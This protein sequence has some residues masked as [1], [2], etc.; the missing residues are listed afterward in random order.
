MR[1]YSASKVKPSLN[2][3]SASAPPSQISPSRTH[4]FQ[5]PGFSSLGSM[6]LYADQD[7]HRLLSCA[8]QPRS[9]FSTFSYSAAIVCPLHTHTHKK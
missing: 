6:V 9:C 5:A 7:Y 1:I 8:L 4:L 2:Q 3:G